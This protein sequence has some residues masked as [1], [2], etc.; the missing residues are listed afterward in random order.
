MFFKKSLL[1]NFERELRKNQNPKIKD[2]RNSLLDSSQVNNNSFRQNSSLQSNV[3]LPKSR[4]LVK[5]SHQCVF[6]ASQLQKIENI[7]KTINATSSE[8]LNKRQEINALR[9][10]RTLFDNVFKTIENSI[11]KSEKDLIKTLEKRDLIEA[12]LE[13]TNIKFNQIVEQSKKLKSEEL[14]SFFLKEKNVYVEKIEKTKKIAKKSVLDKIRWSQESSQIESQIKMTGQTANNTDR[15]SIIN[16]PILHRP[17]KKTIIWKET[18]LLQRKTSIKF[19]VVE[20]KLFL[21]ENLFKELK[22]KSEENDLNNINSENCELTVFQI[23]FLQN[24]VSIL[25]KEVF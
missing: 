25:E 17:T 4:Q 9:K 13:K 14:N 16:N 1:E 18:P 22:I 11:F 7:I 21:L 10:E 8:I 15:L 5:M 23:G 12:Q 2:L 24:E 20:T 6:Q 3:V 19:P